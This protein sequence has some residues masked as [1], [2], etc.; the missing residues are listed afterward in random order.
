MVGLRVYP[1]LPAAALDDL[2]AD[3]Q[4]NSVARIFGPGM[5]PLKH[6]KNIF[7]MLRRNPDPVIAHAEQPLGPR[8]LGL[9]GNRRR[10]FSAKLDRVANQILENLDYLRPVRPHRRQFAM[11]DHR[12]AFSN[13]RPQTQQ[14]LFHR[15]VTIDTQTGSQFRPTREKASRSWISV[16]MR[17]AP[18]QA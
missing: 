18:S 6:N 10:F 8:V 5:Q 11:R 3:G 7:R 16:C 14:H 2:L 15:R 1:D 4:T 9:H 12:A 13:R 17:S